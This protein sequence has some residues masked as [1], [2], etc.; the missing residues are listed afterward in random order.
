MNAGTKV[1]VTEAR[2]YMTNEKRYKG[3]NPNFKCQYY[4]CNGHDK[5]TCWILH[6]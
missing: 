6:P 1:N 5:E 3:K 2:A 4:H